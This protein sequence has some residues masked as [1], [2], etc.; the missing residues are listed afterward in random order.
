[1]KKR[2]IETVDDF[3]PKF[4]WYPFIPFESP[5]V[6]QGQAGF[7]KTTI[8]CRIMAEQRYLSAQIN[9]WH[10]QRSV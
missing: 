5:T 8:V 7:G 4:L 9:S 3:D 10:Y 2:L 1:M 6:F